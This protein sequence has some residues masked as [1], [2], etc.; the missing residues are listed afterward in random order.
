MYSYVRNNGPS[1]SLKVLAAPGIARITKQIRR[2]LGMNYLVKCFVSHHREPRVDQVIEQLRRLLWIYEIELWVNEIFPGENI[3]DSMSQGVES[4]T[5]V[6]ILMVT[7]GAICS[8]YCQS[9]LSKALKVRAKTGLQIIPVLLEG[10]GLP[11]SLRETK[12]VDFRSGQILQDSFQE[13]LGAIIRAS[14]IFH[15]AYWLKWGGEQ[16]RI[17]SA[18]ALGEVKEPSTVGVL[19]TV[20]K[21]TDEAPYVR[22]QVAASLGEIGSEKAVALLQRAQEG[23]VD[24]LVLRVIKMTLVRTSGEVI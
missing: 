10:V 7:Q 15:Y 9:E 1:I 17:E 16:D 8:R 24:S 18:R 3:L 14:H 4:D 6:F 20:L 13:L 12:Y 2:W 11:Q 21:D 22:A 5:Q 19:G 23:E